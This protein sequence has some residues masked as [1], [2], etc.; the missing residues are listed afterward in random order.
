MSCTHPN[1]THE[2]RSQDRVQTQPPCWGEP[3]KSWIS[4]NSSNP[5]SE[6]WSVRFILPLCHTSI[7][8]FHLCRLSNLSDIYR[9]H[10][11]RCASSALIWRTKDARHRGKGLIVNM[12]IPSDAVI[13]FVGEWHAR[14]HPHRNIWDL[15]LVKRSE[16]VHTFRVCT[17]HICPVFRR[18]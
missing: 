4:P 11:P 15:L 12:I 2:A 14:V 6:L 9:L 10:H 13:S 7:C 8:G 5:A 3:T 17:L 1:Y 16:R 18:D